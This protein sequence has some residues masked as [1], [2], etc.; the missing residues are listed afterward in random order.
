[1]D[2]KNIIIAT[3]TADRTYFEGQIESYRGSFNKMDRATFLKAV[4]SE[5]VSDNGIAIYEKED[6][7][8]DAEMILECVIEEIARK[9]QAQ[10]FNNNTWA[11]KCDADKAARKELYNIIK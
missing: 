7:G 3:F 9:I 1:M 11:D 8:A 4:M 10:N 5:L 2:T 6:N